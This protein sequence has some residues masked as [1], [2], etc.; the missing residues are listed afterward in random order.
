[1]KRLVVYAIVF[2]L[3]FLCFVVVF[4][5]ASTV[6]QL[7]AA[8]VGRQFPNFQ[9]ISVGGTVWSGNGDVRYW[10]FPPTNLAWS[11]RPFS[12][13]HG[14]LDLK[15]VASGDDIHLDGNGGAAPGRFNAS[16]TG[17]VGSAWINPVSTNYGLKFTGKLKIEQ[18]QLAADRQWFTSA[19]GKLHWNGGEVLYRTARGLQTID[20]PSMDGKLY[21][22]ANDLH[23][24]ITH[25]GE[26]LITIILHRNGWV[27]V[28]IKERLFKVANLPWPS[29]EAPGDTA[30]SLEEQ[31]FQR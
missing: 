28:N 3:G 26:P 2:L 10:N 9:V 12:L 27:K 14:R 16:A 29:G 31:I 30:L 19:N 20:L 11:V 24:D 21:E 17:F 6:W 13:L 1:M 7:T 5:P 15:A 18:L 22:T 8:N 25:G 23:L 4:L